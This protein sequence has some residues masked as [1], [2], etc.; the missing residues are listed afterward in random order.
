MAQEI[1]I[2]ELEKGVRSITWQHGAQAAAVLVGSLLFAKLVGQFIRWVFATEVKGAAF[3]IS[4][5]VRYA[6]SFAGVVA[7]LALLGLPMSTLV[8]TSSALFIGLGFSLQHVGRDVIAGIVILVEQSIRKNDFVSFASTTGIVQEIG[9]RATQLLTRDGTV[10]VVPNHLL[11][12]TEVTNHSHPFRRSRVL[13]EIPADVHESTDDASEAIH[14]VAQRHPEV[15]A[16][17]PPMVRLEAIEP[18]AFRFLLVVWVEEP[19]AVRRV[20]SELRFAAARAFAER[21]IAFPTATLTLRPGRAP[22]RD[23]DE[24]LAQ[25]SPDD[26]SG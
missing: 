23:P 24:P 16:E 7:A 19:T 1:P 2:E 13:V 4:K 14:E 26:T 6:L 25:R 18:G 11:V 3:A 22:E 8:L 12:T 17:P 10:L 15:L 21:G 5:L 20:A 9:L